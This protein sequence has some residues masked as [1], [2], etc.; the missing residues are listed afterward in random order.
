[1]LLSAFDFHSQFDNS[2]R[3]NTATLPCSNY[4]NL[5]AVPRK[6]RLLLLDP[7]S[8]LRIALIII[9]TAVISGVISG[10]LVG[11]FVAD[12]N[13][14][15]VPVSRHPVADFALLDH[16]GRFHQLYKHQDKKAVI[17]YAYSID[18]PSAE[19]NLAKLI[20]LKHSYAKQGVDFF[21]ISTES[22]NNPQVLKAGIAHF[23]HD[24]PILNDDNRLV[25]EALGIERAGEVIVLDTKV[26]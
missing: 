25:I 14:Y 23:D 11:S 7:M 17:L 8:L 18:C 3:N 2:Y 9:V 6:D 4:K 16:A 15:R 10:G 1:M 26:W 20:E 5:R 12:K 21:L 24:I 13:M 22:L 19:D